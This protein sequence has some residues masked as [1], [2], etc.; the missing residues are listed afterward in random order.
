L[1]IFTPESSFHFDRECSNH[2]SI[3]PH[4]LHFSQFFLRK[5]AHFSCQIIGGFFLPIESWI[6]FANDLCNIFF[7]YCLSNICWLIGIDVDSMSR[8]RTSIYL[9]ALNFSAMAWLEAQAYSLHWCTSYPWLTAVLKVL[10]LS[11]IEL[12]M[13]QSRALSK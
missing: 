7:F 6:S 5:L 3:W 1:D 11:V 8:E 4:F 13:I 9:K 2:S 10:I 12:G